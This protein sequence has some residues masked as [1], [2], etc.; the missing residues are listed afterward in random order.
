MQ[1]TTTA[2]ALMHTSPHDSRMT[3]ECPQRSMKPCRTATSKFFMIL[4]TKQSAILALNS[5]LPSSQHTM[6]SWH[7]VRS[8]RR[9][10]KDTFDFCSVWSQDERKTRVSCHDS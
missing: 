6:T 9:M 3:G 4:S 7:K 2:I 8:R 10:D 1:K 5:G